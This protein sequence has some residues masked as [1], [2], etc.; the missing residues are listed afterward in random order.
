VD[1]VKKD[2]EAVKKDVA[3]TKSATSGFTSQL[4][5]VL[6]IALVAAL[7]LHLV[8]G[9]ETGALRREVNALKAQGKKGEEGK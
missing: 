4:V 2:T 6:L 5:I 1:A 9:K 8:A 7:V 3:D